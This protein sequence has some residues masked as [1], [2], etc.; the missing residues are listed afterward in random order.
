MQETG[1]QAL[2]RKDPTEED[3]ATHSGILA[4]RM[5]WAE[6]AGGATVHRVAKS[7]TPLST[8]PQL[9]LLTVSFVK[10]LLCFSHDSFSHPR[11]IWNRPALEGS[12]DL[13]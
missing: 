10:N 8:Q 1:V 2:V 12:L 4:W 3:M 9:I 5:P 7:Q 13:F 6:E 11:V